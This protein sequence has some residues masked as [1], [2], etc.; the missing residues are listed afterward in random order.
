MRDL[1]PKY[2][3]RNHTPPDRM[4]HQIR[5]SHRL[6]RSLAKAQTRG[7]LATSAVGHHLTLVASKKHRSRGPR[8]VRHSTSR[9][10]SVSKVAIR[11]EAELPRFL[12]LPKNSHAPTEDQH[13][14]IATHMQKAPAAMPASQGSHLCRLSDDVSHRSSLVEL[15]HSPQSIASQVIARCRCHEHH[16]LTLSR[17][18]LTVA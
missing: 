9:H 18:T 10:R 13:H 14:L 16:R 7:G 2:R 3:C 1:S 11:I 6:P 12:E 17:T 8:H 4:K 5:T 15:S